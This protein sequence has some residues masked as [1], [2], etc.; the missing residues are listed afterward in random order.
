MNGGDQGVTS[1]CHT[2]EGKLNTRLFEVLVEPMA[3][4]IAPVPFLPAGI[5]LMY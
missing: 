1:I 2:S 4:Q 3:H 5:Y